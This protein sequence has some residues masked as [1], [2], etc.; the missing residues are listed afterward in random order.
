M[1]GY[2]L[3]IYIVDDEKKR[4][5]KEQKKNEK[6]VSYIYIMWNVY[7]WT[8]SFRNFNHINLINE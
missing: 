2:P 7:L 5:K 1:G 6:R 4:T 3:H 8:I